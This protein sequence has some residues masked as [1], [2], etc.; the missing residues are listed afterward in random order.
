MV[1]LGPGEVVA[2]GLRLRVGRRGG[3]AARQVGAAVRRVPL[4]AEHHVE[5]VAQRLPGAGPRVE[6]GR[7]LGVQ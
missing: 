7:R 2:E 3:E 6:R 4:L 1:V 5:A